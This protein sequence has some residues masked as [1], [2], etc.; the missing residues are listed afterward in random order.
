MLGKGS[1]IYLAKGART[2]HL[3]I[4]ISDDLDGKVLTV[5]VTSIENRFDDCCCI[6]EPIEHPFLKK[7]SVINFADARETEL[8]VLEDL[9]EQNKSMSQ[10]DRFC[11]V[12]EDCSEELLEKI[13]RVA[14]NPESGLATKFKKFFEKF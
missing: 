14:K 1:T 8:L 2:P 12:R 9:I 6:L 7:K 11:E 5:N 10:K 3:H 4:I 13:Q